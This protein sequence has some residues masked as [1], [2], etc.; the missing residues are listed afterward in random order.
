MKKWI[1]KKVKMT[2]EIVVPMSFI[3]SFEIEKEV[4]IDEDW[5]REEGWSDEEY[6][7][8]Q[9]EEIFFDAAKELMNKELDN[10]SLSDVDFEEYQYDFDY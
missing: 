4:I 2:V 8:A 6:I 3:K 5:K 7:E 10:L 1:L 9:H